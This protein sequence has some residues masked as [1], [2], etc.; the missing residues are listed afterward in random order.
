MDDIL[1]YFLNNTDTQEQ[2]DKIAK[3]YQ[4][5]KI[6][7]YGAG[8]FAKIIFE[9]YD[10]SRLNILAIVDK[11]FENEEEKGFFGYECISPD[12]L[13]SFECDILLIANFNTRFFSKTLEKVFSNKKR[14]LKFCR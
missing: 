5:K 14:I 11:K 8:K 9:N 12:E 3:K 13:E 6:A 4:N 1:Q 7:I 2:I 10:L